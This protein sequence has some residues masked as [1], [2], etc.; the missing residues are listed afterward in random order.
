MKV[1]SSPPTQALLTS[2]ETELRANGHY[3]ATCQATDADR[4]HGIRAAGRRVGRILGWTIRT[5]Q[6]VPNS[7]G[8]VSVSVTVMRSTP[9]HEELM[10]IRDRKA[11]RKVI[12]E[13]GAGLNA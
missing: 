12:D 10:R 3:L 6:S 2:I 1:G 7:A 11:V 5:A 13:F 4:I 9:L 8:R